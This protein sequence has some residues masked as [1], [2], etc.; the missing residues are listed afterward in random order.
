MRQVVALFVVALLLIPA[1]LMARSGDMEYTVKKGDTLWAI[2]SGHLKDPLL[3]PKL[4]R[5]N[6][7]VH[8][9]HLIYPNQVIVIPGELLKTELRTGKKLVPVKGRYLPSGTDKPIVPND[10]I[11]DSGFITRS[12]VPVGKIVSRFPDEETIFGRDSIVHVQTT[13]RLIPDT[14]FY[15]GEMAEPIINPVGEREVV[16]YLVKI[17]GALQIT[18]E[19]NG[20]IMAKI[21]ESY[22]E[23]NAGDVILN[24]FPVTP[25]YAPVVERTPLL[26]GVIVKVGD[27]V[28]AD[29]PRLPAGRTDIVYINKGAA[30]G[31][32]IGDKFRVSKGVPPHVIIG[33][34]Q[35]FSVF[36][37]ASI[38][39]VIKADREIVPGDTFGN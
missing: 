20:N 6:A 5:A 2:S 35:V 25:P 23:I 13:A 38:A 27:K 8:N 17:K 26:S 32:E 39:L 1:V 16:G 19:E 4:W 24:Y 30:Q 21:T 36:D 28:S 14:K 9:P 18:G 11:L 10:V 37:D 15:I 31:I 33:A 22:K 7:N 3:W 12:F 34:L 29:Q